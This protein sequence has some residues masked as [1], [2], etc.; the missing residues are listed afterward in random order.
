[1]TGQELLD[2][3]GECFDKKKFATGVAVKAVKPWL[4]EVKAK[5]ESGEIDPLKNTDLDK[6]AMLAALDQVNKLID[7]EL[8]KV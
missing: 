8:A 3:A 2:L 5:V 6:I 1:M 4:A 7:A